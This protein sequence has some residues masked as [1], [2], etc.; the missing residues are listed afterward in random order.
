M[1]PN[2]VPNNIFQ[3]QTP[4]ANITSE[5]ITSPTILHSQDN[6]NDNQTFVGTTTITNIILL[7]L[8]HL[9]ITTLINKHT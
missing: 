7:Y 9:I 6:S 3:N 1:F 2:F 8:P 5:T 4:N